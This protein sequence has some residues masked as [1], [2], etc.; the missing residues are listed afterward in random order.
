MTG[1]GACVHQA[2]GQPGVVDVV[3]VGAGQSGLSGAY[4]LQRAGLGF[5]VL[6]HN[7]GP[8]GAWQHRWPSLTLATANHVHDL[9]GLPLDASTPAVRASEVVPGYFGRYEQ[10]FGLD[11]ARPVHTSAVREGTAGRLDVV[12]S[13]GTWQARAVLSATGTWER[14]FRPHYPGTFDGEQLHAADYRT[15]EA[16]RG[17]HVVVVGG[18]ISAVQLLDEISRVTTTTWVTRREPVW[19]DGAFRPEDGRQAVARVE[20]RVR[21][22]LP[23]GSVVSVTGLLLTPALRAARDRGVLARREMFARLVP[24]GVAWADGSVQRAQVVLWCTGFRSALDH[25]APLHL[26]GPGGGIV[27]DGELAT[28]GAAEPRVH[29]LGYGPSA[30]TIGANRAGRAAV[31]EVREL[32][33]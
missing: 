10:H 30:S 2:V 12:T 25:L 3:V 23:P 11:V 5:A 17:R 18:G 9:P 31:R 32:L 19:A 24:E 28:R 7:P 6:D 22:G 33:T 21:A 8:G 20:R 1:P 14:P 26:R 29:L 27:M 15:A 16:F 13:V 4:F